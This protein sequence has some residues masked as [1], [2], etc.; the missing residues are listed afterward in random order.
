MDEAA[1]DVYGVMNI[2]PSFGLNLVVFFAALLAGDAS[3]Q[4][5]LRTFSGP[6][7]ISGFLDP[8][9]TDILRPHLILGATEALQ[10]LRA[11][12]RDQYAADLRALAELTAGGAD[13]VVIQGLLPIRRGVRF[14]VN[15]RL[16]L[17]AMQTA[18]ERVGSFIATAALSALGGNS[19]QALETWDDADEDS[20]LRIAENMRS[21]LSVAGQGDDAALLAAATVAAF[22]DPD[23]YNTITARLN[24]ALDTSFATDPYWG[25]PQADRT[26]L[27]T[28][29]LP[30]GSPELRGYVTV[31]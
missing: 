12:R 15:V 18:A 11:G 26:F 2:G 25:A 5:A 28:E 8:H 16:P 19:I 23:S 4:P 1:S 13:T 29:V 24:E 3:A 14:P 17:D 27:R 6:D 22:D 10:E 30:E 21:D 31:G 20:A 9:P 7:P